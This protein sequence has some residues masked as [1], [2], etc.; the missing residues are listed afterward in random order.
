MTCLKKTPT[1]IHKGDGRVS[2]IRGY[3][4]EEKYCRAAQ[5]SPY[6]NPGPFVKRRE[7]RKKK[8]RRRRGTSH[9]GKVYE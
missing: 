5:T 8:K 2:R 3:P 4:E 9:C 7:K 1:R 6:N